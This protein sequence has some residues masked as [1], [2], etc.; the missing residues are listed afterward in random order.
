[1][2][3]LLIIITFILISSCTRQQTVTPR[4]LLEQKLKQKTADYLIKRDEECIDNAL[5]EA[6]I[7]VDS[8]IYEMTQFSVLGDSLNMIQKPSKPERPD[9]LKIQDTGPI[10]PFELKNE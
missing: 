3:Y 4:Q 5:L 9:Y 2:R 8:I 1:M 6:E 10:V 7:Y